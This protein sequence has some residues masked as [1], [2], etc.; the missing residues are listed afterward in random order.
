MNPSKKSI[1]IASLP[2]NWSDFNDSAVQP[3][4]VTRAQAAATLRQHRALRARGQAGLIREA[5]GRYRLWTCNTII[6]TTRPGP[7][8]PQKGPAENAR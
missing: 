8:S 1:P 5:P 4:A 2:D 6:L 3:W 7:Q